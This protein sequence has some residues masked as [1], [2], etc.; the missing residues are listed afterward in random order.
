MGSVPLQ[1]SVRVDVI[2]VSASMP[3]V[4]DCAG[5]G[6]ID[7]ALEYARRCS[8]ALGI[9]GL[10]ASASIQAFSIGRHKRPERQHP[11]SASPTISN[12]LIEANW[13]KCRE[14]AAEPNELVEH[15]LGVRDQFRFREGV[16]GISGEA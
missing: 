14:F 13:L 11:L 7:Q 5:M 1:R 9:A 12:R 3:A 4:A 2:P 6:R 10:R 15:V 16:P 8:V